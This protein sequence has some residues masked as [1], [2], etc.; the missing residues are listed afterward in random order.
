MAA[1]FTPHSAADGLNR[2]QLAEAK[3]IGK[4]GFRN[5]DLRQACFFHWRPRVIADQT[6]ERQ[7]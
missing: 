6:R 1:M 5:R 3:V 7:G 4:G 2:N